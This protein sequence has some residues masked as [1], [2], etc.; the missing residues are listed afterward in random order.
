MADLQDN[1]VFQPNGRVYGD[2]AYVTGY[3]GY[4]GDESVQSGHYLAF[5]IESDAG[6]SIYAGWDG[7]NWVDVTSDGYVVARVD[8]HDK[9]YVKTTSDAKP[10]CVK[11]YDITYLTLEEES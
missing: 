8:G 4:S 11:V 2:L 9:L 3:T 6:A 10:D 1:V 5:T 7:T